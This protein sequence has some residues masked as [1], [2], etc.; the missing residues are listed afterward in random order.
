MLILLNTLIVLFKILLI[1]LQ[2]Q[3]RYNIWQTSNGSQDQYL[4]SFNKI[5]TLA[6]ASFLIG[7]DAALRAV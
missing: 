6:D 5:L 3:C 2:K 1:V 4:D 7:N